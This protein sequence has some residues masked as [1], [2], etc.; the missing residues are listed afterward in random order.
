MSSLR[1][2]VLKMDMSLDGYVGP[3]GEDAEWVMRDFDDEL[4]AYIV[5]QVLTQAGTH[6]M[7]RVTYEEMA[8]YWPTA[9][10][11]FA[12]P[13]NEIPKVVFSRTLTSADWPESRIAAGELSEEVSRLKQEPGRDILVHGGA[14]LVQS[15][16]KL[17][18][19]DEYR[20]IVHPVALG[21]GAPLFGGPVD[22][23]LVNSRT[24]AT[25][26]VALTYEARR[27]TA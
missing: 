24:F 12:A 8:G 15:L 20:V 26:A 13:M 27:S 25:G 10:S 11:V 23:E 21:D 17:G 5:D 6:A 9:T 4:S 3:L 22:L 14:E 1:R 7:G 16:S 19:I 18:L 2:L